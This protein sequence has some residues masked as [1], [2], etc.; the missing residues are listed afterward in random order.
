MAPV[1]PPLPWSVRVQAEK[2]LLLCAASLA[3]F[4]GVWCLLAALGAG[5]WPCVWKSCTAW[6]CA[7]C[8][9]TRAVI[10]LFS[11][12]VADAWAMNPGAVLLIPPLAAASLYA[13]ATLVFRLE[14]WR[15]SWLQR[16]PWRWLLVIAVLGN[17]IYLLAAGRA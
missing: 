7:G 2:T 4:G 8:G 11:G 10:L 9:S 5:P 15:P 12:K 17:W 16:V 1:P 6:P 3:V 14:P 13:A